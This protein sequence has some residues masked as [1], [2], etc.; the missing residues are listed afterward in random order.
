MPR[1]VPKHKVH[2]NDEILAWFHAL[3]HGREQDSDLRVAPLSM[4]LV[5]AVCNRLVRAYS[6][7]APVVKRMECIIEL[8]ER[9]KKQL[10]K[11]VSSR[12]KF[13]PEPGCEDACLASYMSQAVPLTVDEIETRLAARSPLDD[14]LGNATQ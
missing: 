2:Y 3:Y 6:V 9:G 13:P 11:D 8:T 12:L 10:K 5:G 14:Y 4:E 7:S 1:P